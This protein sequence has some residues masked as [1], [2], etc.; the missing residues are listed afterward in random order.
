[1]ENMQN[2]Y[3][4]LTGKVVVAVPSR[5]NSWWSDFGISLA[6]MA[7][8]TATM[9]P[10][11]QMVLTNVMGTGLALNRINLCKTA[12]QREASH[13]LFLDDDMRLPMDTLMGLIR[14]DKDIVAANCA[15]KELWPTRPT[16]RGFKGECVYTRKRSTG[17]EEVD[18]IGTGVMLI[19][20]RVLKAMPQPWFAEVWKPETETVTG[21]DV[22]F[23]E[24]ARK[25]GFKVYIDHDISKGVVH[26]GSFEFEHG[27]TEEWDK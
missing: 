24:Q 3:A 27:L 2:P 25:H 15:R 9:A 22:Y 19:N 26:M 16:A 14:H 18:S 11:I 23:C 7:A 4:K 1:M 5:N 17:L 10:G 12:M 8:A 20:T 13:I 6:A 21:E